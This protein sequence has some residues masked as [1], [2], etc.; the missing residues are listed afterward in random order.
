[1]FGGYSLLR[2]RARCRYSSIGH[3]WRQR[4]PKAPSALLDL[5]ITV[6][7]LA[8]LISVAKVDPQVGEPVGKGLQL[9]ARYR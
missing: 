4:T 1:M 6:L 5:A 3:R 2:A 9:P 8:A 7:A